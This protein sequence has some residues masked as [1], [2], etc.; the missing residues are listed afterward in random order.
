MKR[1][2]LALL[3]CLIP[4]MAAVSAPKKDTKGAPA[5]SFAVKKHDF[6]TVRENGGP[7]SYE[8]KFTNTGNAPLVII[9]ANASCGCTRPQ[10]PAEPIRPGKTGKIKVTYLPQGR[11]GEFSKNIKVRTNAPDAKKITLKITG[12]VL[13]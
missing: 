6:G 12:N 8:F 10:C 9:S 11:P 4:M 13:P 7:I 2:L 1:T 5:I 3:L